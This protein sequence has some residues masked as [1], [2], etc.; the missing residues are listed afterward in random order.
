MFY[1]SMD[2]IKYP[3][4]LAA[5]MIALFPFLAITFVLIIV[6]AFVIMIPVGAIM[7]VGYSLLKFYYLL[8]IVIL[9]LPVGALVGA[10]VLPFLFTFQKAIP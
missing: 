5:L 4:L 2:D 3:F 7:G 8:C 10:L 1:F 6:V 9:L